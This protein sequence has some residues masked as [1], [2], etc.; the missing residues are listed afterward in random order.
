MR[1][2]LAQ[3][4][5]HCNREWSVVMENDAE[6]DASVWTRL[7]ELT[8]TK[9]A[10]R[11][12]WL[13]HGVPD[14]R[15]GIHNGPSPCCTVAMAFNRKV[16]PQLL[17]DLAYTTEDLKRLK[18]SSGLEGGRSPIGS[19][20]KRRVLTRQL[21]TLPGHPS[22]DLGHRQPPTGMAQSIEFKTTP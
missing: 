1:K 18:A 9:P 22:L 7:E 6:F 14:E 12:V 11:V 13:Q 3:A 4:Q 15:N 16:L 5:R 21:N 20:S 17:L 19:G 10:I 2:A 8:R